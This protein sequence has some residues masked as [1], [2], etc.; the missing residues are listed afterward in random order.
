MRPVSPRQGCHVYRLKER[1]RSALRQECHVWCRI[2]NAL[3][4]ESVDMAL[5]AECRS[6]FSFA[7]YKHFSPIGVGIQIIWFWRLA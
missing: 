4:R 3:T 6:F 1:E 7:V 5:L 2:T